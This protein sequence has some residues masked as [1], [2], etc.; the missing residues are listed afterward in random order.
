[1]ERLDELGIP[2]SQQTGELSA[3]QRSQVALAIALSAGARVLLLDE[4]LADLDPLA[5]R[6]FLQVLVHSVHAGHMTAVL[7]SHVVTDIQESCDRILVLGVGRVLFHGQL[8][9]A[10][11]SH[12]VIEGPPA[13]DRK[14]I[15]WF[16][17]PTGIGLNLCTGTA[18]DGRVPSVEELVLGYLASA[19][20]LDQ[21]GVAG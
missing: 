2:A 3:G 17:G 16:K 10:I 11:A 8:A 13:T 18:G 12:I 5:R 7:T 19:R 4:P 6:D 1:L 15:G 21:P 14:L 9:S 20:E